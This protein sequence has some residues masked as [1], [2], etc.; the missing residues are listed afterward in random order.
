MQPRGGYARLEAMVRQGGEET[1]QG[2]G[3]PALAD[4]LAS[5][6]GSPPAADEGDGESTAP[7]VRG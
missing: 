1:L 6:A 5:D 2:I 7:L 4:T 3:T